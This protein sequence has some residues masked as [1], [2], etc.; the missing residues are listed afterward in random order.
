MNSFDLKVGD[1]VYYFKIERSYL[2]FMKIEV[3]SRF[4]YKVL[5]VYAAGRSHYVGEILG[6]A[7]QT[8]KTY[9]N[10]KSPLKKAARY[11]LGRSVVESIF[12]NGHH[13]Y[14]SNTYWKDLDG[15]EHGRPVTKGWE[16]HF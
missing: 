3:V 4:Q 12:N 9:R 7:F 16:R 2:T 6:S 10:F 5:E 15:S 13:D 8:S 11:G 1:V 14:I